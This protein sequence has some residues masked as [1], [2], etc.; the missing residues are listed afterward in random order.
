MKVTRGGV[1]VVAGSAAAVLIPPLWFSIRG[2][3]QKLP[4]GDTTPEW[5]DVD[6]EAPLASPEVDARISRYMFGGYAGVSAVSLA[7]G[8]A[9]GMRTFD[10]SGALETLEKEGGKRPTLEAEAQ[11]MRAAVRALG[12]G[13]ALSF[14]LAAAG[15]LTAKYV[16]GIESIAEFGRACDRALQPV[17]GAMQARGRWVHDK[18]AQME[19][20][21]RALGRWLGAPE[22]G[23]DGRVARGDP[24]ERA[25]N[26]SEKDS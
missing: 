5:A 7:G 13:T 14:G 11:A 8:V 4:E 17:N 20:S 21:G 9:L 1:A 18:A 15:V 12:W 3:P 23:D 19:A 22:Y 10:T 16:I 6:W 24:R 25:V 2:S 26:P